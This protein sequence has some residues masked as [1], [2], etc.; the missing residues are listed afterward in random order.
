[1]KFV[2]SVKNQLLQ[3]FFTA[4][5]Q[6]EA[7]VKAELDFYDLKLIRSK[8]NSIVESIERLDPQSVFELNLVR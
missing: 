2:S 4:Q 3:D 6:Y 5:Q 7:A 8:V 1:M